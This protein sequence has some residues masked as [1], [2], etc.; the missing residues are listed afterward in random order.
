MEKYKLNNSIN[1]INHELKYEKNAMFEFYIYF[2]EKDQISVKIK[3]YDLKTN[4]NYYIDYIDLFIKS[5]NNEELKR[6][7]ISK[8]QEM[9]NQ[10][11]DEDK[12]KELSSIINDKSNKI[13][14]NIFLDFVNE[15]D[16]EENDLSK[17][18]NIKFNNMYI[19]FKHEIIDK[20]NEIYS[21]YLNDELMKKINL[22]GNIFDKYSLFY[23][24]KNNLNNNRNV[25]IVQSDVPDSLKKYFKKLFNILREYRNN[26]GIE[27]LLMDNY[28]Y[29]LCEK[30]NENEIYL[31]PLSKTNV[32]L[33]F[34]SD[35]INKDII[36]KIDKEKL[37][38]KRVYHYLKGAKMESID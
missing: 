32:Q 37:Y 25:K 17:Y 15:K 28:F 8:Y 24:L 36:K 16:Y 6:N 19:L 10:D 23:Y 12:K 34:A 2:D 21:A 33:V 9:I 27:I 31:F 30:Y 11:I 20:N 3:I 7:I 22:S 18:I 38:S 26:I 5:E 4:N 29:D 1:F 13:I 14:D 35:I